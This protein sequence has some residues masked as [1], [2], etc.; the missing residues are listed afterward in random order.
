MFFVSKLGIEYILHSFNSNVVGSVFEV[1]RCHRFSLSL[2]MLVC[3]AALNGD[4]P[5]K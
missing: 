2:S 5:V 3:I 4:E 1:A